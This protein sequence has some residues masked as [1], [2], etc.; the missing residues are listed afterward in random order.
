MNI[1][2]FAFMI[3]RIKNKSWSWVVLNYH[4]KVTNSSVQLWWKEHFSSLSL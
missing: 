3:L 1:G 4:I 2:Q